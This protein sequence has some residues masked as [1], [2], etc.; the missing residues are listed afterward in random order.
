M[1]NT[2]TLPLY[3]HERFG[4]HCAGGCWVVRAGLCPHLDSVLGTSSLQHVTV[5]TVLSQPPAMQ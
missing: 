5:P 2:K 1:V 3:L 4:T